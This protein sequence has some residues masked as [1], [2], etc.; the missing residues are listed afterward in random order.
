M[1]Y[2]HR[3]VIATTNRKKGGEMLQI[4]SAAR[5]DI[6]Y[7]FL[8]A[9]PEMPEVDETGETFAEN[10]I[11]KA[12][13]AADFT[14]LPS[15]ADDGGLCI[16]FL[17]GLPGVKSHRFLGADTSFADKMDYILNKMREVP[18]ERRACRFQCAVAIQLPGGAL[19]EC[20]GVCEGRIAFERRGDFGFGYDPI[21]FVPEL[22][23][24]MAE[25]SPEE[26]HRISHRGKALACAL[27]QLRILIP[28]AS[29]E[30]VE[31]S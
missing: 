30:T 9:F 17:N 10:A 7:L 29:T 8:D 24:H 23:K 4:L 15:I 6:E 13:A 11:L 14:G 1:S 26:K 22:G 16:D 20:M 21:F 31:H 25:L 28:L 3:I 18:I 5:P 12:R 19:G 2:K 27:D